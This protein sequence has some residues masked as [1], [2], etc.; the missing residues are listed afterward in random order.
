MPSAENDRKNDRREPQ[1]QMF[2]A[3]SWEVDMARVS[4]GSHLMLVSSN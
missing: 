3:Q 4:T 2:I 1:P